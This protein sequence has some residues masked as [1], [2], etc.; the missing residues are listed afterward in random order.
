MA[1]NHVRRTSEVKKAMAEE[2]NIDRLMNS[3]GR[4]DLTDIDWSEVPKYEV[5]PEARRTLQY[6]LRTENSTI[7]YVKT[8]M[9]TRAVFEEPELAPFL[10]VWMYEEEF[11]GRAFQKFLEAYG[12]P[13]EP[14]F[15]SDMY[16]TRGIGERVDEWGQTILGA[17]L[18]VHWPAVHMTW[19]VIQEFT[20]FNAYQSLIERVNHPILTKICQRI[21]KQEIRHYVFYREQAKK[22]LVNSAI[23]RAINSWAV[24]AG[25]TPVGVGMCPTEEAVHAIQFL[26]DGLDG[27]YI[28]KI[29][30]KVREMPGLEWFDMFTAFARRHNI[31]R[32]P[33]SWLAKDYRADAKNKKQLAF[34]AMA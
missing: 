18:P 25:W 33:D 4:V 28:S 32:A 30:E 19:G 12:D 13:I 15:R 29:E 10:C 20:T 34:E 8:L 21:M 7:Y 31:G 23:T 22:R 5:T 3:S 2:F 9:Q 14:S 26:F 6:F 17:V 1:A 16:E 27:P 24:K 11:H